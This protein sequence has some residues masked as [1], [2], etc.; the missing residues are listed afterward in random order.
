MK[1]A[2]VAF[3]LA[4]SCSILANAQAIR[5]AAPIDFQTHF[6]PNPGAAPDSGSRDGWESF[7]LAQEAGYDPSIQPET[8]NGESVLVR[9]LAP[10]QDGFF[11]LGFIRRVHLLSGNRPSIHFRIR[12]PYLTGATSVHLHIFRGEIDEQHNLTLQGNDW[13]QLSTSLDSSPTPITA[14][15]LAVD[16]PNAV[17]TRP[18]RVL[19][20]GLHLE[21]LAAKH[22]AITQPSALWDS[23]RELFYLQRSIQPGEE[24]QINPASP[25]H[26]TIT[27]PGGVEVASGSSTLRYRL[28]QDA[29]PGIWKIHLEAPAAESTALL[30]VRPARPAGLI[31]DAP[32]AI[33]PQ[34]L[35][36]IRERKAQLE[37]LTTP[38]AGR[39]VAEM[40][41]RWLLPGLPSYFAEILQP[42][43]LALMDA[44]L[45]RA[46][47]D[48]AALEQA[49]MLLRTVASWPTWVHPWFPAH[50]YHSYYPVGLLTKYLVMASE[51]LGTDLPAADQLALDHSLLTLSIKPAYEEYVLEDRLQFNDS[52]WIGNTAGGALLAAL[53]SHDPDAAGYALGLFAKERDHVNAAYTPD[54]SYGEGITYHRFDLETTELV[55][56][57]AKRLL[58]TSIDTPLLNPERYMRYAAFSP[59]SLLDYGDSHVDLKLANVFAYIAALNQSANT[60]DFYFRNRDQGTVQILPRVLWESQ[61]KPVAKVDPGPVSALFADRGIAVLRD[62]WATDSAVLAMRAGKNFNHNHADQGSVFYAAH[63]VLWLSEAGYA[64]YY[65]DP[66]YNTFNTQA[67]GHNTLLV[68]GNPESQVLPGNATFGT[69]PRFTHTLF[70]PHVSVAQANLTAVYPALTRYTRTLIHITGGPTIVVDDVASAT[71][72]TFTSVWHPAQPIAD[73]MP[74]QNRLLLSFQGNQ[75]DLRSFA[76]VSIRSAMQRSPFPLAAYEL[77]EHELISAPQQLEVSTTKPASDAVLVTTLSPDP[78]VVSWQVD[79]LAHTLAVQGWTLHISRTSQHALSLTIRSPQGMTLDLLH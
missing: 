44:M 52:N 32:P 64:D 3:C 15:A 60:T 28:P 23:T 46:T 38:D 48:R 42:S 6:E 20:A 4:A 71:P 56:A 12:A 50:G 31:F 10:T 51:F 54:G 62:N 70:D 40:S 43:E 22:I 75:L 35:S 18:E 7:P 1:R 65:K 8:T 47:G 26:W 59:A 53:A 67:I 27:S 19:L 58:G 73:F 39:N 78:G 36:S 2:A 63:G 57:A 76:D 25:S 74:Q 5:F 21:A 66:N 24:L 37:K 33:T 13:Q 69:A 9:E 79:G 72:H 68:D 61:I 34:L 11:Q 55:A 30:L 77:S 17:H 45:F 49:T 14:L 29:Q 16:C 41:R